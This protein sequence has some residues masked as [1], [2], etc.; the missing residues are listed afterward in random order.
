MLLHEVLTQTELE[1]KD[2]KSAHEQ[3][4][5]RLARFATQSRSSAAGRAWNWVAT[6]LNRQAKKGVQ[7][8]L[9]AFK[10]PSRPNEECC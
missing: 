3:E 8:V 6:D 5:A 1:L 9:A 10:R 4:M 2:A 7:A